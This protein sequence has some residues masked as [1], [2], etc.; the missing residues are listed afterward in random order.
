MSNETW[1]ELMSRI[2]KSNI[3]REFFDLMDNHFMR[4]EKH[5][6]ARWWKQDSNSGDFL[7]IEKTH[8]NY[9]ELE[10]LYKVHCKDVKKA[11]Q[12]KSVDEIINSTRKNG[13]DYYM[14]FYCKKTNEA[15]EYKIKKIYSD[16][17]GILQ[18]IIKK[19]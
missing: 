12:F 13:V 19:S 17:V 10:R 4:E 16:F 8:V 11:L 7:V 15:R 5:G 9:K 14:N 18:E 3:N 2:V 1:R 6:F